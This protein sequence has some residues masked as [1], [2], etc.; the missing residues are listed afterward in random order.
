MAERIVDQVA[1]G[2]AEGNG[3]DAGFQRL[4]IQLQLS[5]VKGSA[6]LRQPLLQWQLHGRLIITAT[7][8]QQ[9]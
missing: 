2:P 8:E 4:Q 5:R 6:Q 3:L 7:G 1:D 9:E